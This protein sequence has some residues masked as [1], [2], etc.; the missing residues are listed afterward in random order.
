MLIRLIAIL[1]KIQL[2][3]ALNRIKE[4]GVKKVIVT[5]NELL[6]AA[7][8]KYESVGFKRVKSRENKETPFSGNYID[9][10]LEL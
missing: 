7:Q 2:Q 5:T 8:K 3:E 9:Y 10:E 4:Y 6:I 1:E